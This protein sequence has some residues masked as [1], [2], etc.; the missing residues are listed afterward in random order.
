MPKKSLGSKLASLRWQ[1]E[2]PDSE[3]FK[4][5]R[6]LRKTWKKKEDEKTSV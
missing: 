3:Y 6:K 5:I 1:K 4:K 2:K